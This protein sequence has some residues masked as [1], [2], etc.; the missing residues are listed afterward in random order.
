MPIKPRAD[1]LFVLRVT[2]YCVSVNLDAV[3]A[4][5]A[6]LPVKSYKN[7]SGENEYRYYRRFQSSS[8]NYLF[9]SAFCDTSMALP[10]GTHEIK[11]PPLV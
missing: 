8:T 3:R 7:K 2:A 1:A 6:N 11:R 5:S 10:K 9:S 4:G